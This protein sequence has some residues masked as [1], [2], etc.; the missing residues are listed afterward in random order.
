MTND[1]ANWP[2]ISNFSSYARPELAGW[3]SSFHIWEAGEVAQEARGR[4]YRDGLAC[5]EV[6]A[7]WFGFWPETNFM[8]Q[9]VVPFIEMMQP[10]LQID[11]TLFLL[12]QLAG[13]IFGL[14]EGVM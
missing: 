14:D 8:I 11:L 13:K 7:D 4:F 12:T 6:I 3:S 5:Q 9:T 10:I 2:S 1:S